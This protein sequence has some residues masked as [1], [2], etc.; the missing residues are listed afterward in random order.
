MYTL[1]WSI[2]AGMNLQKHKDESL[3]YAG[4]HNLQGGQVEIKECV[5][6]IQVKA[7]IGRSMRAEHV[8]KGSC[9]AIED[10]SENSKL[11]RK[12]KRPLL[13]GEQTVKT[14]L[15][16]FYWKEKEGWKSSVITA[17]RLCCSTLLVQP[18]LD[19]CVSFWAL[20]YKT[21]SY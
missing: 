4:K 6:W 16:Y 10:G 14:V 8:C 15:L 5:K 11:C 9:M 2:L 13:K 17:V 19:Y 12:G 20:Q 7:L 3:R 18:H 1:L 21:W